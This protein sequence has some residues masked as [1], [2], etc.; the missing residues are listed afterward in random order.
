ML[1]S[2]FVV[3]N[4]SIKHLGENLVDWAKKKKKYSF[5]KGVFLN[6]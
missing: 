1:Y 5:L 3:K 4:Q 2:V 6:Y